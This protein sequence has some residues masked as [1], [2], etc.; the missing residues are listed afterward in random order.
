MSIFGLMMA[1]RTLSFYAN[2]G[3]VVQN[4]L[5]NQATDGFKFDRIIAAY[6][7]ATGAPAL[8]RSID[9]KQG[10]FEETGNPFHMALE[11]P[12]FFVLDTPDGARLTRNGNFRLN[13]EHVLVDEAN[14]PVMGQNGPIRLDGN[15]VELSSDGSVMLDGTAVDQVR[16][17]SVANPEQMGK[18]GISLF[19]PNGELQGVDP[20]VTRLRQ[21]G[22]ETSNVDG[23][24]GIGDMITIQRN[25]AMNMSA[26]QSMDKMLETVT[27]NVGRV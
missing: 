24:T 1:A 11:G 23:V 12:G 16:L 18:D 9:M 19:I 20:D 25:F 15:K 6:D 4:N 10:T 17:V 21:F 3:S 27:T 5:A 22:L 26:M 14:R 13:T 8:N 7:P 2:K